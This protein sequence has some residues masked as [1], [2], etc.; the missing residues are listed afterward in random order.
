MR[1]N[2]P[3][4]VSNMLNGKFAL[5][6]L[7]VFFLLACSSGKRDPLQ[8]IEPIGAG[9]F[10]PRAETVKLVPIDCARRGKV[11]PQA[12]QKCILGTLGQNCARYNAAKPNCIQACV[13]HVKRTKF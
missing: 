11:A 7:L 2:A 3:K 1:K 5:L 12:L 8:E 13:E 10:G 9:C 6:S 4:I